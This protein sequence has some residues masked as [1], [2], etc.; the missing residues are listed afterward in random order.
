MKCKDARRDVVLDLY[1]ELAAPDRAGLEDHLRRCRACAAEREETIRL[2]ALLEANP[3]EQVPAPDRERIWKRI[4]SGLTTRAVREHRPVPFGRRWALAGAS[5]VFVLAAGIF[6][7]RYVFTPPDPGAAGPNAGLRPANPDLPHPA[8][9]LRPVLAGHLD[10]LKPLLLEYA[11]AGSGEDAGRKIQVDERIVRAL[12]L[13]N[14]LL[15]RALIKADP[16]SAELLDDCDLIL[17]E[18]ITRDTPTAASPAA[19][20]DLIR[21]RDVLFKIDILKKS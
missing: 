4:E 9:G 2:F 21:K 17:R 14:V 1:G 13:Q 15:R 20:G 6:I 3:P 10:D 12:L 7:G 5:L 18:I 11:N 8:D 19:I 16:A